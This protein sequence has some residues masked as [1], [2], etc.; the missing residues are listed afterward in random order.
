MGKKHQGAE[1]LARRRRR[2]KG[3]IGRSSYGPRLVVSRSLRHIRGQ[4]IDDRA[5]HTLV[6][7]STLEKGLAEEVK[8]AKNGTE[9]AKK[10][11]LMLGKRAVEKSILKVIFDRN[12]YLYH[13][14]V[15]A[16]A[17]GAREAGL[18]F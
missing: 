8:A 18:Q 2:I 11:G 1:L 6:A 12:G 15:E 10:M 17:K 9:L 5:G 7:V 16:F 13:G 14:R 3:K 4:I